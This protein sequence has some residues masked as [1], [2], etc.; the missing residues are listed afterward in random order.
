[1]PKA[2]MNEHDCLVAAQ[3][4]V[5][6]ARQFAGVKAKAQAQAMQQRSNGNFGSSMLRLDRGHDPTAF[7]WR[8]LVHALRIPSPCCQP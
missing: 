1:M 2:S 6:R 7:R 3:D 4:D 8:Y 5:G